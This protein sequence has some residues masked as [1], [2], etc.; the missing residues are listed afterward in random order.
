MPN[1]HIQVQGFGPARGV[2]VAYAHSVPSL[3]TADIFA[4]MPAQQ[5]QQVTGNVEQATLTGRPEM[6]TISAVAHAR[7]PHQHLT[8]GSTEGVTLRA[9]KLPP[10]ARRNGEEQYET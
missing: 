4:H 7:A 5:R 8:L 10:E 6:V 1:N 2:S 9:S 3:D